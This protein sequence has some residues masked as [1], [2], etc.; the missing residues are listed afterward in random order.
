MSR[1]GLLRMQRISADLVTSVREFCG[2]LTQANIQASGDHT[3]W[4]LKPKVG[5]SQ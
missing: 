3:S 2:A 1:K 5:F 4:Y